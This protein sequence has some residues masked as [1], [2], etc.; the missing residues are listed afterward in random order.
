MHYLATDDYAPI[1]LSAET[2][3]LFNSYPQK[4]QRQQAL[5]NDMLSLKKE[6]VSLV[7]NFLQKNKTLIQQTMKDDCIL[8]LLETQN[9]PECN[10]SAVINKMQQVNVENV[11]S[12]NL[13]IQHC[14][15]LYLPQEQKGIDLSLD[16]L[17][18]K[19]A[20]ILPRKTTAGFKIAK[21]FR[22]FWENYEP[23]LQKHENSLNEMNAINSDIVKIKKEQTA[24]IKSLED[25]FKK[26]LRQ[27]KDKKIT[28]EVNRRTDF[29]KRQQEA[30]QV[31]ACC[32]NLL[33]SATL[34]EVKNLKKSLAHDTTLLALLNQLENIVTTHQQNQ[35]LICVQFKWLYKIEKSIELYE[36]NPMR[37][38]KEIAALKK[39]LSREKVSSEAIRELLTVM[40]A[41]DLYLSWKE[42]QGLYDMMSYLLH[43]IE[44][45]IRWCLACVFICR[46]TPHTE[47][48]RENYFFKGPKQAIFNEHQSVKNEL[49]TLQNSDLSMML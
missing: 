29:S 49:S 15:A 38:E 39:I 28:P 17:N 10:L 42:C 24:Q 26:A 23:M 14:L 46:I 4:K 21:L 37:Y 33:K 47:I 32:D 11:L 5:A 40:E 3:A 18:Q 45:A 12:I 2:Q 7:Q 30:C 13:D 22:P 36:T 35:S 25:T 48:T 19:L 27:F 34:I 44:A 41:T 9:N 20:Q 31:R 8:T 16:E 43:L 6:L 1:Q